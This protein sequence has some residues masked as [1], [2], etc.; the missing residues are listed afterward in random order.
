MIDDLPAPDETAIRVALWRAIH[1]E[2]DPPP[3]VLDDTVGLKLAAAEANWRQRPDMN[4]EATKRFR[5]SILA[6]ARFIEYLVIELAR[7]GVGQYAILGAGL[8]TFAH[9][10]RLQRARLAAFGPGGF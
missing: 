5:A 2:S 8:E 7:R 4:P 6:R 1:V 10:T 3:H 9:R